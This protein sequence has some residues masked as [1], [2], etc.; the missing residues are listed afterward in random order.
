MLKAL[1]HRLIFQVLEVVA[2]AVAVIESGFHG[3][4][5]MSMFPS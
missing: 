5:Q 2:P 3:L 1:F 4:L